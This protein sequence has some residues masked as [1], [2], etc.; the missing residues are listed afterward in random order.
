MDWD[1]KHCEVDKDAKYKFQ[2]APFCFPSQKLASLFENLMSCSPLKC[3]IYKPTVDLL[4][5]D[6]EV[7]LYLQ[8]SVLRPFV[9][10]VV[11]ELLYRRSR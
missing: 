11:H 5:E 9:V 10:Y 4:T 1:K 2:F 7:A 3:F 6:V 8:V